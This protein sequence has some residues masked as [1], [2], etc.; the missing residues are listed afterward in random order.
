MNPEIR[1]YAQQL[2]RLVEEYYH[3]QMTMDDYRMQ[4]KRILDQLEAELGGSADSR[5]A[6]CAASP[7][8]RG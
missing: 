2:R 1:K 8:T 5:D 4:R 6:Q 3:R 7:D